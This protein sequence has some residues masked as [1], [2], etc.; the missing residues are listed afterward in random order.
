MDNNFLEKIN[1]EEFKKQLMSISL[2][3]GYIY[4]ADKI[5]RIIDY[6]NEEST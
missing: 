2:K 3:D 4:L 6:L 5:N 1:I